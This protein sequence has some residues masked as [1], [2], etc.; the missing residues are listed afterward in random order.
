MFGKT[1]WV[2]YQ[3][4]QGGPIA[5]EGPFLDLNRASSAA[6]RVKVDFEATVKISPPFVATSEIHA[7]K[8]AT[9]YL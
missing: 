8:R 7:V 2:A 3:G 6:Q 4:H 5:L 1:Y 9:F